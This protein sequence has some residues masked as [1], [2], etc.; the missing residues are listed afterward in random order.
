VAFKSHAYWSWFG[1]WARSAEKSLVRQCM[2]SV[3]RHR[4]YSTTA[5]RKVRQKTAL[6]FWLHTGWP[7][8]TPSCWTAARVMWVCIWYRVWVDLTWIGL[9]VP[10]AAQIL[11]FAFVLYKMPCGRKMNHSVPYI[12]IH[13]GGRG[14][15]L[16]NSQWWKVV[17]AGG[18]GGVGNGRG[19]SLRH[20]C[21]PNQN[22]GKWL[23]I[24]M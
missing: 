19:S 7:T 1:C 16:F 20:T 3:Y 18:W 6:S 17:W 12:T 13:H 9:W 15:G 10:R 21:L 2:Q 24:R 23:F 4:A 11:L 8:V 5:N 14:S 22:E